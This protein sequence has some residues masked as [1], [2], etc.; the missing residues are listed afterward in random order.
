MQ[1]FGRIPI[2]CK[3]VCQSLPTCETYAAEETN[4]SQ[5]IIFQSSLC[6]KIVLLQGINESWPI[7]MCQIDLFLTSSGRSGLK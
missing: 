3:F 5:D 7:G 4:K 2:D 1:Y 6:I